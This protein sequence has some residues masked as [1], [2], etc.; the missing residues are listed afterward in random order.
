MPD[1]FCDEIRY[2]AQLH[3]VGKIGIEDK[4][5]RKPAAL[6]PEEFEVM[7]THPEKGGAIG[8]TR[9]RPIRQR[10]PNELP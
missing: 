2:S 3:D 4:I 10:R 1:D 6:T 8:R 7:K 5:L 9:A